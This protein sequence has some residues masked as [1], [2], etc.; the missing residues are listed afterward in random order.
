[1]DARIVEFAEVLRQNGVRVSTS[2]VQDALSA[3][4]EVGLVDRSLFRAVLRTTLVKREL[5]VETF[6]RAFDFYFSG[7]AR[8]FEA[9]DQSLAKQLEEEG[10]L[11]GDL[12][13]MVIYQM[14]LLAPEMS[15]LAQAIL[16]G[17]RARLAQI[18]RQA[19]LQLD[20][21]QLES[22]LQTGFFTRRLLAGAGMER[23]RSDLKSMEDEL[24]ARGLSAEGIEIV[25]RHVAAAMRKIEDAARQEVKRQSEARIRR[26]TDSVT[27]KPLH[28]LTQAEVD[29]M[30]AAVRTMAEK[31]KSR[32]IRKQRSHRRGALNVRRTLRRNMPWDGIPMV[33]QF[34]SRR[35]E[36][37]ELVVL[38]DVSDS[39]RNASRMMLLF[40]H[41]LQSLFVRVRSFVFVSDVGEV[42]H[43]FKDLDV[44]EA[45]DA[46]TAGR[47]VSMS[48]NS[49]YG[50]ALAD[51]TRDHLG[52]ITRRTT[53]MIIGD[54][55]NNY[56]ASN[57][58][59]L[60]DLR[61]KAKRLL[62]ICPEDRGNWGIG[63]S[64]ML[65]YEKHCHQA[66]VVT[67]VSDLARIADQLVP[68]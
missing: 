50:R 54:G 3:T 35:P 59:A 42:T 65:T 66:V 68:A 67:S 48:A 2:E 26:R 36:R 34:R 21:G 6:S 5:D 56:N 53:V 23:A 38:C 12:L 49:N 25:S 58:W 29:E 52:S 60:K 57:A 31:L 27:E 7:A 8:T 14:N 1:M 19:S 9:I 44:S 30:E 10:Y 40:M 61:R 47:T 16:A 43:F 17:D 63:D 15:P 22:P 45:I 28:L 41:T 64:E 24:H 62:W 33:P 51:F 39:V 4:A 55:R 13:K 18:F 46:A 37:P 11:E 20:L 32:L